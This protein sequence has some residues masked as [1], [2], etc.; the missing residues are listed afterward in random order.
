MLKLELNFDIDKFWIFQNRMYMNICKDGVLIL[1]IMIDVFLFALPTL[2]GIGF[3]ASKRGVFDS[4]GL[5][6]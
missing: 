6:E 3:D 4:S 2:G 1:F 5:E